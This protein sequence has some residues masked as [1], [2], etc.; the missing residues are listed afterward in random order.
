VEAGSR[1][2][3]AARS[4]AAIGVARSWTLWLFGAAIFTGAALVFVIQPMVAKMLL[5][6]FGGTAAVWAISL[7]FFQGV[8]LAGYSLAHVSIRLFGIRHQPIVQLVLLLLPLA[9]LPIGL[10]GNAAPGAHHD[11]NLWLLWVLAVAA[12][13]P[14]LVITTASPVLQRWFSASGHS[15]SHDPYFLYAAGN[16]GSLLGLLAYPTLIEPRLTLAE[17]AQMWAIA[18]AA[19]VVLAALCATRVLSST[20]A[21]MP[22]PA[23][24]VHVA[25]IAWRVRLRWI[26]MAAIPSALMIGTS[27]YLSTDVAAVP[28]LW[29]I[30]LALYL[31]SFVV[32]F[33]RR[34]RRT[35]DAIS[36]STV[37]T[38]LAVAG[39]LLLILLEPALLL[40]IWLSVLVHGAN[41]FFIALLVHRRLASERPPAER[42]TEFY[43]L[44]SVGG[45]IGGAF[46]ALLAPQIFSTVAEYPLAIAL[47][48]LLRPGSFRA[49]PG[50]L[51]RYADILLPFALLL[52]ILLAAKALP[53]GGNGRLGLLGAVGVVALFAGRPLRYA[54]GIAALL[55]IASVPKTSLVSD[56]NFF[57]VVRVIQDG[58]LH[59]LFDGTTVHGVESFAPGRR[60]VPLA[61]YTRQGPLGQIFAAYGPSIR[62]VGAIGLGSGAVAAYGRPGDRFTFYEINP[63]MV[64]IASNPR[65]FTFLH[66]SKAR[67]RIVVGDGRLEMINAPARAYDLI[68][69]DAFSS[70]SVPVH[71]LTREAARI[72]LSKL[73]P[74]G[75]IAFHIS[76]R[77]FDLE[78]V[79]GGLAR[80]LHLSGLYEAHTPSTAA[81]SAG[82]AY[83]Q[84]VVVSRHPSRLTP[85][86]RTGT[87]QP[88]DERSGDPLWTD[89]YSNIL[90]VIRWLQ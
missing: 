53:E 76:N 29:V 28:L 77:Y 32:A 10:P 12:G 71:L 66:D 57:G 54:L 73:R 90:S 81:R 62:R 7:V 79:I 17:Q 36:R 47:A 48:L 84:W 69:L 40:P 26:G 78:P 63:A 56:R 50:A 49:R 61:Y 39:L 85:L 15:A 24:P 52:A 33:G 75:L 45:V 37:A 13:L 6:S 60:D 35:L 4:G 83:S 72:Y 11:P 88:L 51:R 55:V 67:I 23:T 34:S 9:A 2:L 46:S 19:F 30:P 80:S 64:T 87:W 16:V 82:A 42:L 89:Q 3:P 21:V 70:D 27:T 25:P 65:Y 58:S 8:L 43:L 59:V 44:L 74:G 31:L 41:L 1:N 38:S 86:V 14:F 20:A 22:A 5:P 18:Y 68:V